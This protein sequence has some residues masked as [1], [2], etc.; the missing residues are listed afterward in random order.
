LEEIWKR[1]KAVALSKSS[2]EPRELWKEE[3]LE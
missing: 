3:G 1:T 2:R